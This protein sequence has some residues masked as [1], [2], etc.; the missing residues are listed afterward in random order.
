MP[1]MYFVLAAALATL[2]AGNIAA[3]ALLSPLAMATAHRAGIPPFLM[4][5]MV[6]HGAIAGALSPFSPT[7]VIAGNL[8]RD[9]LGLVNV[10]WQVYLHNLLA[11]FVVAFGGYFLFGGWRLFSQRHT[12]G[13]HEGEPQEEPS[14]SESAPERLESR[15][16]ETL[17]IIV[18]LI[19]GVLCFELHVGMGAF[20][21]AGLMA[22]TR[23]SD[24]NKAIAKMPWGVILMVCGVTVLTA[25][26]EKTG[27]TRLL[28]QLIASVSTPDTVAPL[29]GFIAGVVSVYSSTSGV[30]LPAFLP[31]VPGL[32]QETGGNALA[33][34]SAIIVV[35]HLVD[36]SPLST[37]GALCIASG[38]MGEDRRTLFNQ[39]LLWGLAMAVVG[40]VGCYLVF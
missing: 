36:S 5:I 29:T 40:A 24:E 21:G 9:R 18:A 23:L 6:S 27:G 16:V 10:E 17:A 12:P 13:D 26:L 25:L 38:G 2:G 1:I 22:L 31:L 34:A 37:I 30:V 8:L 4:A 14:P 15:H 33:L 20:L 32:A 7:G 3:S 39:G 19:V 11:N 28:T 35:G